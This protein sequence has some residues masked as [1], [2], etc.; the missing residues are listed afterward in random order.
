MKTS[1]FGPSHQKEGPSTLSWKP[2]NA[3]KDEEGKPKAPKPTGSTTGAEAAPPQPKPKS[4][5]GGTKAPVA[6]P[7]P[8]KPAKPAASAAA[9]AA[10]SKSTSAASTPEYTP[11]VKYTN[12]PSER[13]P[14]HSI[15]HR[16]VGD[17]SSAWGD[18]KLAVSGR[19]RE[20]LVK[21][22]NAHNR[23]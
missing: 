7:T 1:Y 2:T 5:Q 12:K 22:R 11:P 9:A 4:G 18:S 20:L 17:L 6:A 14:K 10:S 19:P 8:P 16:G 23:Q 3:F 13:A 21:V 15:I